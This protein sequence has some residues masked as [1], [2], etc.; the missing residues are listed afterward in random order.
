MEI[1]EK[2]EVRRFAHY[3]SG[4]EVGGKSLSQVSGLMVRVLQQCPGVVGRYAT[5]LIDGTAPPGTGRIR[6]VLPLPIDDSIRST[7]EQLPENGAFKVK[8]GKLSGGM[9]KASYRKVGIDCLT[10]CMVVALNLLW[11]GL[12]Q[13][14]RLPAGVPNGHQK[15]V[16]ERLRRA[17]AYSLDSKDGVEKGGVPRAPKEDWPSKLKDSRISYKGEVIAKAEPLELDRI[18]AGLPPIGFGGIVK[19]VDLCEGETLRRL[20][21]PMGC[22]LPSD[23]M[24]AAI[25]RPRVRVKDMAEWESLAFALS[26]RGILVPVESPLVVNQTPILNGMFGVEKAGKELPDGR[27]CQRLIMDLRGSNAVLQVLAGDISTLSGASAFT[28]ISL[29]ENQLI[30]ISGDDLVSSFY[31]FQLPLE[32]APLLTF[33][34]PISW[35]ALGV[36]RAGQTFLGSAVLPMG[37]SSS[38]GLMQHIHRRLALWDPKYGA[39]LLRELEIRKDREWPKLDDTAPAWALYLDDSTFFEQDGGAKA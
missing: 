9:I 24:P 12:G 38:V 33:E 5:A 4:L 26:E 35:K 16:L 1:Q 21:D 8:G 3:C 17:A 7:L 23:E 27:S 39:G 37:F 6:D 10:Y 11:G 13:S 30:T 29:E 28:T 32:W 25:P 36:D 22:L 18:A 34:K 15:E 20:Q 14:A 2:E 31:L 19:L